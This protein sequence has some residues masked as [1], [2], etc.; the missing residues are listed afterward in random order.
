MTSEEKER[1][2]AA[3][4]RIRCGAPFCSKTLAITP[5]DY[6]E[7][8]CGTHWRNVPKRLRHLFSMAKRRFKRRPDQKSWRRVLRFWERC[9][10]EAIAKGAFHD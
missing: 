5:D 7:W 10:Q 9:K 1:Q 8:I 2:I 4:Q 6:P 3:G